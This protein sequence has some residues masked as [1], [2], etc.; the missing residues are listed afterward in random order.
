MNAEEILQTKKSFAVVGAT[1]N[2]ECYGYEVFEVLLSKGY[3]VFPINPKYDE[4]DGIKCYPSL[5]D[6]DQKPE[7]VITALAPANTE[8]AN[9]VA[10][11]LGIETVWMT[12]GCW[13]D[14]AV[15]KCQVL[16]LNFVYDECPVGILKLKRN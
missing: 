10:K 13:S 11:E 6:L 4:I 9:E 7:V 1:Q 12:P 3:Q 2:K 8:K 16:K 15:E 5:R 14:I